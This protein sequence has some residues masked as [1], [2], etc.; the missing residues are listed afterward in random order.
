MSVAAS[1]V[2][3]AATP[4]FHVPHGDIETI[5][6][7]WRRR[8]FRLLRWLRDGEKFGVAGVGRIVTEHQR[9]VRR[10]TQNFVHQTQ[11]HLTEAHPTEIGWQMRGPQTSRLHFFLQW[12]YHLE[13]IVVGESERLD[14]KDFFLHELPHPREFLF[15]FRF[16]LK[17]PRHDDSYFPLSM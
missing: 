1:Q 13:R 16:C 8:R 11:S 17:I 12:L 9:R 6:E 15:K 10:L 3:I 14:G 4:A 2:L 5:F 7:A